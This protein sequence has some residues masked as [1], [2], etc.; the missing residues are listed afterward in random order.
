MEA[1]C[2]TELSIPTNRTILALLERNRELLEADEIEVVE[3][4][5]QHIE[6]LEQRHIFMAPLP[7]APLFPREMEE[8]LKPRQHR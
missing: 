4:F 8:L 7:S 2:S 6:G 5:R 3:I 1:P